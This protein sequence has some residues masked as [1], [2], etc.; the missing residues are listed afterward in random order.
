AGET[1]PLP[2]EFNSAVRINNIYALAADMSNALNVDLDEFLNAA[3]VAPASPATPADAQQGQ[4]AGGAAAEQADAGQAGAG[5]TAD[6]GEPGTGMLTRILRILAAIALVAGGVW[7]IRWLIRRDDRRA[8]QEPEIEAFEEDDIIYP[9]SLQAGGVGTTAAVRPATQRI[10]YDRPGDSVDVDGVDIDVD[11]YLNDELDEHGEPPTTLG[12]QVDPEAYAGY[13]FQDGPADE[14]VDGEYR[15]IQEPGASYGAAEADRYGE[16]EKMET[17]S[18]PRTAGHTRQV[19]GSFIGEHVFHYPADIEA[20]EYD[21]SFTILDQEGRT[22]G[23]CG[24]GV[25]LSHGTLKN[26]PNRVIALDSWLFDKVDP[27]R[28]DDYRRTLISEYVVDHQMEEVFTGDPS[29]AGPPI[30]AQPGTE[31]R[32]EGHNLILFC[33]ILDAEYGKSGSNAGLFQKVSVRMRVLLKD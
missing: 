21:E 10:V 31:Y 8:P 28:P 33:T 2:V 23:D 4:E 3:G 15:S 22:I 32:L 11:I 1:F 19:G 16:P 29:A 13:G 6:E 30:V 20:H 9:G 25:N 18:T 5:Q 26:D 14:P 17:T 12:A 7:M 24:L 27:Q